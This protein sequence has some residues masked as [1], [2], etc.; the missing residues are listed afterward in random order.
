MLEVYNTCTKLLPA[1]V[2]FIIGLKAK[3]LK[4]NM[5]S[6]ISNKNDL[7]NKYCDEKGAVSIS[8]VRK[9]N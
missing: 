7:C 5:K 4:I 3:V 6:D 2:E 1:N 9:S 8:Y